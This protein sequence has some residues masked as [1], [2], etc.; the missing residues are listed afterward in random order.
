MNGSGSGRSATA[1][2]NS[3]A[4][5]IGRRS[6]RSRRNSGSRS[7]RACLRSRSISTTSV[8][9]RF[10]FR[11]RSHATAKFCGAFDSF[12]ASTIRLAGTANPGLADRA[13][14]AFLTSAF[15]VAR[16]LAKGVADFVTPDD[17]VTGATGRSRG[18]YIGHAARAVAVFA[19]RALVVATAWVDADLASASRG[20]SAR[21]RFST[22]AGSAT[23]TGCA[24]GARFTARAGNVASARPTAAHLEETIRVGSATSEDESAEGRGDDPSPSTPAD[25]HHMTPITRGAGRTNTYR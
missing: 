21:A 16:F 10:G 15:A 25:I 13:A 18:T 20:R 9:A 12:A 1:A 23:R 8:W 24:T 17:H 5:G 4:P 3:R 2:W 11:R 19:G 22:V 14:L 6:L 7:R